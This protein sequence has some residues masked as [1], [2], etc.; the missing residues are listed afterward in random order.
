[1]IFQ[2]TGMSF[3][4]ITALPTL[5]LWIVVAVVALLLINKGELNKKYSF[6]IYIV[7]V[8]LGGVILGGVPNAILPIQTILSAIGI[9]SP[10]IIILPM[11][12]MIVILLLTVLLFGR[13]F[14]GFACP[15]GA[16]QEFISK[17][18]FT[19]CILFLFKDTGKP[20]ADLW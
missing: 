19:I 12:V 6:I 10:I 7:V 13:I 1:M 4:L 11:I 8:V 17:I 15:V 14:C 18:N 16:L 3:D 20:R 5:L 9:V 2:N